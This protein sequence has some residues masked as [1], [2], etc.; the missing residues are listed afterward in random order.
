MDLCIH[1]ELKVFEK[2]RVHHINQEKNMY[3]QCPT[4][5]IQNEIFLAILDIQHNLNEAI[6]CEY[7]D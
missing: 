5:V 1:S 2:Y 3:T 4:R 7:H 6:D